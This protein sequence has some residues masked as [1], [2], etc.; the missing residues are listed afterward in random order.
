MTSSLKRI[1]PQRVARQIE[2]RGRSC[3]SIDRICRLN[4]KGDE[5]TVLPPALRG[6]SYFSQLKSVV[7]VITPF[8]GQTGTRWQK[9]RA[10]FIHPKLEAEGE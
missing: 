3:K 4:R 7:M 9:E 10:E 1:G 6:G 2:H 5:L 8:C